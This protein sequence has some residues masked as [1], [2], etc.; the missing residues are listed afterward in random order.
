MPKNPKPIYTNI[1]RHVDPEERQMVSMENEDYR[2]DLEKE[3]RA[4]E[5]Y[6][7][8]EEIREVCLA[9]DSDA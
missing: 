2:Y 1:Y 5:T 8:V 3:E 7:A 6:N 9:D 4:L